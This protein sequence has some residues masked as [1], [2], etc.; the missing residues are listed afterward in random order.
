MAPSSVTDHKY[1]KTSGDLETQLFF[2][3]S[4]FH[5]ASW[6]YSPDPQ[7]TKCSCVDSDWV[8]C[9]SSQRVP[10]ACLS[11]SSL[12]SCFT[13]VREIRTHGILLLLAS[14]YLAEYLA[15][16][17]AWTA[18]PTVGRA[19]AG[20]LITLCL[21]SAFFEKIF[22]FLFCVCV[23]GGCLYMSIGGD[24]RIEPIIRSP[25]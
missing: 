25:S 10:G 16:Q 3:Y 11:F 13:G 20:K 5:K 18:N 6:I 22:Y 4:H 7:T 24:Q 17:D 2:Q 12:H 8:F 23:W 14:W 1:V 19:G 15:G 9:M 21:L